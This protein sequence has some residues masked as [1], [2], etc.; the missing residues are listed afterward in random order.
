MSPRHSPLGR[1][2]RLGLIPGPDARDGRWSAAVLVDALARID[3]IRQVVATMADVG[4]VR[5]D[6]GADAGSSSGP[7]P[8]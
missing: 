4:A 5:A 1:A 6:E 3:A 7:C 8:G 2:R